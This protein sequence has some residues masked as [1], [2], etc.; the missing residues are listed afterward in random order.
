MR[1]CKIN[2]IAAIDYENTSTTK[3]SRFIVKYMHMHMHMHILVQ[4]G[5][6]LPMVDHLLHIQTVANH[7]PPPHLPTLPQQISFSW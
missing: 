2:F 7:P 6:Q 3:F 5:G 4:G 1:F